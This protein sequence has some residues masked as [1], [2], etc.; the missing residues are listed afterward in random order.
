MARNATTPVML[1][2][3]AKSGSGLSYAN[4]GR[5]IHLMI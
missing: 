5:W 4:N 3:F 2:G 1:Q